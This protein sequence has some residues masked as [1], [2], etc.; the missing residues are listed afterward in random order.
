ML[1]ASSSQ[2]KA[3]LSGERWHSVKLV[4]SMTIA[5]SYLLPAQRG[6]WW[7]GREVCPGEARN[8]QAWLDFA[9]IKEAAQL[10][11]ERCLHIC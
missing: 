7:A 9:A 8:S 11:F 3:K 6:P 5:S 1:L 10:G 4:L 2:R